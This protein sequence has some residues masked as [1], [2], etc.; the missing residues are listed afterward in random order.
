MSASDAQAAPPAQTAGLP[1]LATLLLANVALALGPW[2][3]RL[4]DTGPVAAAF[5]R[6]SLA[7]PL[8][9]FFAAREGAVPWRFGRGAVW[10]VGIAGTFFALDLASWH[11]GIERTR[12]GNAS[13]FGNSGS[14]VLMAWGLIAAQRMPRALE[15][16]A[17]V[18]AIAGA[19]LLM[20]GSLQISF[21]SFVGDVFCLAAGMFYAVYILALR[22][23]RARFGSWGVLAGSSLASVPILLAVSLLL[24]ESVWPG[25]WTPLVVLAM[26]SQVLGQGALIYSLRFFSPLVIGLALLTQPAIAAATGWLAFGE[27]LSARD[28]IGMLLLA[29]ALVIVRARE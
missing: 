18:C 19:G 7:L 8:L 10:A 5:W 3:V 13:L 21:E 16:A 27:M 24:R 15:M 22:P 12:L 26:S 9:L 28:M 23:V 25:D 14:V 29:I 2:L 1:Q 20:G 6:I 4:A 17:V 11:L